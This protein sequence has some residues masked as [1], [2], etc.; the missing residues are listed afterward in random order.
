MTFGYDDIL[1]ILSAILWT[2]GITATLMLIMKRR[3]RRESRLD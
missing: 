3:G 2:T 1:W